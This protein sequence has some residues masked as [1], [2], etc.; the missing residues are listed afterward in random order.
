MLL[1]QRLVQIT[2]RPQ[3]IRH[4]AAV[5]KGRQNASQLIQRIAHAPK[6]VNDKKQHNTQTDTAEY[7]QHQVK[8]PPFDRILHFPTPIK[9][10][11]KYTSI[12][13]SQ[14]E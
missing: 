6:A 2:H 7:G 12:R 5:G 1:K 3:Q 8:V 13:P 9:L 14:Y 4:N 10:Y 11:G